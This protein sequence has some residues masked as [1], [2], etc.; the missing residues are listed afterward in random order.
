MSIHGRRA[1]RLQQGVPFDSPNP[2]FLQPLPPFEQ[3][4]RMQPALGQPAFDVA[5]RPIPSLRTCFQHV[6]DAAPALAD[7]SA[8][9][10]HAVP[11]EQQIIDSTVAEFHAITARLGALGGADVRVRVVRPEALAGQAASRSVT[12]YNRL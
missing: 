1:Q 12:R 2:A 6:G 4:R 11:T 3:R 5:Q 8:D 10:I 9:L 7:L